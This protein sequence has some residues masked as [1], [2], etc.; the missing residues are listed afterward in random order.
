MTP[1]R[2]QARLARAQDSLRRAAAQW[3]LVPASPDFRWLTGAAARVTERMVLLAV[4]AEGA[5][6]VVV[7]RLEADAL[8]QERPDLEQLIWDE[9]EDPFE[10][11]AERIALTPAT[12]VLLGE[13]LRV[14]H[15][16]RLAAH[17]RCAAGDA[18]LAPLRAVKDA[19]ELRLLEQAA[20]HADQVAEATADF[21][22][23][24]CTER[25]IARFIASRFEALG[26]TD[27]WALVASGPNSAL[28]HHHT[29][30]RVLL[31][32]EVL[33][34]DL[35]ASHQ[36]YQSD[37]TRTYCIGEPPSQ[38]L[39]AFDLVDQAR[40]AGI[41]AAR[42]GATCQ[43]VDD[44]ARGVFERAGLASQFVHRTGHG[45]GLEVHE[46]PYLVTGNLLLLAP[47]MVHSVEPGL[48]FPGQFG[49]RLE[50]IVVVEA[51]SGRRLNQ[52]ACDL[53]VPRLRT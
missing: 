26:D 29:G 52:I 46:L 36:G 24:G 19:D 28:P 6:L 10:R 33:L 45:V 38:V 39:H 48:Y 18:L 5:P 14:P 21:A 1:N 4:P 35:G 15:V 17:A 8:H 34:L 47:G 7:P 2:Y 50:D 11:L 9:H 44:A 3:L 22:R 32:D 41:A 16:L 30:D 23:P 12:S 49:I 20:R 53:R 25:E 27:S 13:G 43:S 42:A 51:E 37:I 31:E 40:V